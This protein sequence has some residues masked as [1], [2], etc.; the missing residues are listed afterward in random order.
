MRPARAIGLPAMA[1]VTTGSARPITPAVLAAFGLEPGHLVRRQ[2]LAQL[3]VHLRPLAL[4]GC[5]P[6]FGRGVGVG[7]PRRL[8]TRRRLLEHTLNARGLAVVQREALP[9]VGDSASDVLGPRL[10]PQRLGLLP[11]RRRQHRVDAATAV[12][13]E[14]AHLGALSLAVATRAELLG[15]SARLLTD[16][17]HLGLLR[18]GQVQLTHDVLVVAAAVVSATVAT[19]APMALVAP[20]APMARAGI[21]LA[22]RRTI[23]RLA[24]RLGGETGRHGEG[25]QEGGGGELAEEAVLRGHWGSCSLGVCTERR[26]TPCEDLNRPNFFWRPAR[27]AVNARPCYLLHMP[28]PS[29]DSERDSGRDVAFLWLL[30]TRWAAT[31]AFAVAVVVAQEVLQLRLQLMPLFVLWSLALATNA[32]AAW[33]P[34]AKQAVAGA[35]LLGFDVAV[36]TLMLGI[37]GGPSNPFSVLY[38][39]YVTL[40]A[41]TLSGR[42]TAAL[43]AFSILAYGALFVAPLHLLDPHAGHAGHMGHASDTTAYDAHLYGMFLALAVT[44]ALIA[45]FVTRLA[46]ALK[47]REEELGLARAE[48]SR[49]ERLTALTTLS[50]GAAHE[51][52]T[53]LGTIALVAKEIEKRAGTDSQLGSIREDAALVRAEVDRCRAILDRMAGRTGEPVGEA[54]ESMSIAALLDAARERLH[55]ADAARV[56]LASGGELQVKVPPRA[57]T[58]VLENLVRNGLDAAPESRVRVDAERQA[59]GTVRVQVVDDGPGMSGDALARAGEPFF[60]TKDVG[61]GMGLGLYL[62]RAVVEQL[63]GTFELRSTA[64]VG[65]EVSFVIP[66]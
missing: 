20:L 53:P 46:G 11:L 22:R 59:V 43:T 40:A 17:A 29:F 2:D 23:G 52:G 42:V 6:C 63:G 66:T 26:R 57:L 21:A 24:R 39:V 58:Q 62:S 54:R 34:K 7:R 33:V 48:V 38:L 19:V 4:M 18:V 35:W 13:M 25:Q 64:G 51:L 44:A 56:T 15:T 45:G 28:S 61:H 60:T 27:V 3:G 30:R 31:A 49:A 9:Q 12:F 1:A 5:A 10:G 50:A 16:G 37:A 65:T 47:R 55:S 14:R 32:A 36:L 41:M 8:P